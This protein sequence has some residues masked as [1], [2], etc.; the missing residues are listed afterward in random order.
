MSVCIDLSPGL[1]EQLRRDVHNL[2]QTAKESLLVNL[3]RCQT[4]T[5]HELAES[6][7]LDRFEV[8]ALLGRYGVVEDLPLADA[9]LQESVE[10]QSR[11]AR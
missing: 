6:L 4:I 11:L 5:H 10:L 9:V 3:Y 8:E 2:D 7:G 1:E